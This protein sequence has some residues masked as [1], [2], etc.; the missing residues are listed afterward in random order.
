MERV[1]MRL[2]LLLSSPLLVSFLCYTALQNP[3][4]QLQRY[5]QQSDEVLCDYAIVTSSSSNTLPATSAYGVL[6]TVSGNDNERVEISSIGFY[7]DENKLGAQD[8][9][10]EVWTR[11]GQYADP[12]R[13][14]A[15]NG[16]LPLNETFDYRGKFEYW[17]R[18]AA[19]TFN[20]FNVQ[21]SHFQVPFDRFNNTFITGD[22]RSFYVTLKEVG[23]LLQAP[24]EIWE[25]FGDEEVTLHCL[26]NA[27]ETSC[28]SDSFGKKQPIIHIGE[29]VVAYPF[30]TVPHYYYPKKFIGTI[31]YLDECGVTLRPIVVPLRSPSSAPTLKATMKPFTPYP[32]PTPTSMRSFFE[33]DNRCYRNISTDAQYEIFSSNETSSSYGMLL[34]MQSNEHDDDGVYITSLGFHVDFESIPPE[35]G[36]TVNYEVYSLIADGN[37]ADTNRSSQMT[38]DYRGN[39][40]YWEQISQ[41]AITQNGV[42]KGYFQIPYDNF[43]P[44]YIPPNEGIRSFYLTLNAPALVYRELDKRQDLGKKQKDDDYDNNQKR[45]D[46]VNLL[47]GEVVIGYPFIN[48][49]FLYSAKRFIGRIFQDYDCPTQSPSYWPSEIPSWQPSGKP[50]VSIAPIVSP[51]LQPSL[52]PSPSPTTSYHPTLSPSD[53]PSSIPS[54]SLF[55][56][57]TVPSQSPSTTKVPIDRPNSAI[58]QK[59]FLLVATMCVTAVF[60]CL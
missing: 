50:S 2:L 21:Q 32:T 45:E 39:F 16:G 19:G 42:N 9:T 40:S 41:G 28:Q 51:S 31:Y 17:T 59:P 48:A 55:P 36:G 8:V 52:M 44:T 54:T 14:N 3:R 29:G 43:R 25:E 4:E 30:Y 12:E 20:I 26:D 33:V 56:S 15:G 5:L 47:I 38:F 18:C 35:N 53:N 23:A 58:I 27:D 37:Y 11:Q 6:F 10:Y 22:V 60:F 49:E 34:P 1:I 46:T 57:S 7:V 13:T 24:L